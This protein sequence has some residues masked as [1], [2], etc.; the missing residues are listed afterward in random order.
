MSREPLERRKRSLT[1]RLNA[2]HPAESAAHVQREMTV[3]GGGRWHG[4][5][6]VQDCVGDVRSSVATDSEVYKRG[7]PTQTLE[8]S[9]DDIV[10][11]PLERARWCFVIIC[12][13]MTT[14]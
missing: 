2:S 14:V 12:A 13:L 7:S 10:S 5:H 11:L 1:S 4:Q 8:L 9:A 6:T 3:T